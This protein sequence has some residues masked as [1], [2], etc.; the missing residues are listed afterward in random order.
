MR[1]VC[2]DSMKKLR[3]ALIIGL[4]A[5]FTFIGCGNKNEKDVKPDIVIEEN[6]VEESGEENASSEKTVEENEAEEK[7]AALRDATELTDEVF[8]AYATADWQLGYKNLLDST[9]D[10]TKYVREDITDCMYYLYDIDKDDIPELLIKSG[11]NDNDYMTDIYYWDGNEV[12]HAGE[13]FSGRTQYYSDPDKNGIIEYSMFMGSG[14]ASRLSLVNGEIVAEDEL[15]IDDDLMS[16]YETD[17]E[18]DPIP[19]TDVVKNSKQLNYY[20]PKYTYPL[21]AYLAPVYVS[22]RE[23][24]TD[25]E[26]KEI[27][28]GIIDNGDEFYWIPTENYILQDYV[29]NQN[30]VKLLYLMETDGVLFN[31]IDNTDVFIKSITYDDFNG[32]GMTECLIELRNVDTYSLAMVLFTYQNGNIYAYTSQYMGDW[33]VEIKDGQIYASGIYNGGMKISY[34]YCLDQAKMYVEQFDTVIFSEDANDSIRCLRDN[35]KAD[36]ADL[37]VAYIGCAGNY[38]GKYLIELFEDTKTAF[39]DIRFMGEL[40]KCHVVKQPGEEV[41]VLVPVDESY[42]ISVYE[43]NW[44]DTASDIVSKRG[45]LLYTGTPGEVVVVRC[46]QSD[47]ISNVEISMDMNGKE[48]VYSPSMSLADGSLVTEDG[49]YDFGKTSLISEDE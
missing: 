23:Q 10:G 8:A 44:S 28:D 48:L 16:R 11:A 38:A 5:V 36:N 14:Y 22:G 43:K 18:A 45:K 49:V 27:I 46:N 7:A 1:H 35:I 40:G 9:Y 34:E 6:A 42:V 39:D 20:C 47:I 2:E 12:K 17:L 13:T 19:V 15:L 25:A 29:F 32:D 4:T 24:F 30:K 3:I 31:G 41:Y 26:F 21:L 37:A 33:N